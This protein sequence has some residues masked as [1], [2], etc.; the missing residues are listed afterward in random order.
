MLFFLESLKVYGLEYAVTTVAVQEMLGAW[1]S[2][3]VP[4]SSKALMGQGTDPNV[5]KNI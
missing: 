5:P 2:G 4:H 3:T 1:I